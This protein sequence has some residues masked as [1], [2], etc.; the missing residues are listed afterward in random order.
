MNDGALV[1]FEDDS[2]GLFEPVALTRAVAQLR[3]GAWT[4]RERWTRVFPGRTPGAICRGYLAAYERAHG[5]WEFVNDVPDG[6]ALF[7]AAAAGRQDEHV[8]AI[9]SLAPG[10]ALLAGGALLAFRAGRD[11]AARCAGALRERAGDGL[12]PA[13]DTDGAELARS[14]GLR[15]SEVDASLPRT[16]VDL[17]LRNADAIAADFGTYAPLLPPPDPS[18]YPG[19]HFLAPE[20][21]RLADGVRL[22]PGVVLDA[23]EGPI[24]LGPRCDVHANSVIAGPV[25][26]GAD[27]RVKALSRVVDG[28]S[29]G[30]VCRVGGEVD[31]TIVQGFSNKQHDGFLGHSYLGA[32]VNLGAATDTSDLKNDYGPVSMTIAGRDVPTGAR[33]AGSLLGDH[34]KTAIHTTLNTGT[35]IGVSCNVFGAGFPPKAV[36]SYSWGGGQE[37]REYRID[38]AVQVA[39][40]VMSRRAVTLDDETEGVLRRIHRDTAS[41]RE[42][43]LAA[44]PARG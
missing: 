37:W 39:R 9:R 27:C 30:P 6:D 18:A 32:W 3:C 35:V 25:A 12:F 14:L 16:L 15:V 4:H 28:V 29:L 40:I 24:L 20:R 11:A 41:A 36:P 10:R 44:A 21:I 31:A 7:V 42:A 38:K 43:G 1:L 8:A 26:L 22:D 23:R 5:G 17:I 19:V 33:G 34:T 2:A 13:A